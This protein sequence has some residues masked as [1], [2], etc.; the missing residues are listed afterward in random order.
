MV[1]SAYTH[2][3]GKERERAVK[4]Y[5]AALDHQDAI[6]AQIKTLSPEEDES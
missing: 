2:G 4:A 1:E 6:A 3:K 5:Y